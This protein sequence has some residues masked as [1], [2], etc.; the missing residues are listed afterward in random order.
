MAAVSIVIP[1]LNEARTLGACIARAIGALEQCGLDDWEVLVADNGST[2]GSIEI[3]RLAGARVVE[4]PVRGYGAAL[5]QGI[6]AAK[7]PWVLFADADESYDFGELVNFIP[8]LRAG[9]DLVVGN[10]FAGGIAPGAMP[11]LHRY[12]GTPV[13]SFIGRKSFGV[14]LGDFN[15]GMRAI[16]QKA[17]HQLDMRAPG[18]EF[19]SEMIAKAGLHGMQIA[20]VPIHLHRDNRDRKPHLRTWS[21]GWKH[22]RLMLLLS[23]KWLLLFPA[24]FF[25]LAGLLLG[26]LLVIS[27]VEIFNLIL[28]I[29]TLY[30]ASIFL[31]VGVQ[32][33]QFYVLARHY[34]SSMGLYPARGFS[35]AVSRNLGF[36]QSLVAG[37]LLFLLGVALSLLAVYRWQQAGFGP[38]DPVAVFRIIIPAGFCIALGMQVIVFGFLLF[39]LRNSKIN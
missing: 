38:L 6:L 27:Y 11:F 24:V 39:T 3:A 35:A 31:M 29:H 5:H 8:A 16:T 10:R 32:L 21:D 4:V 33:M 26:S 9:A 17:Y 25:L 19:A 1:C 18:M 22:L 30:Y 13:L 7:F 14:K 15:C 37:G 12:L 28:S 34:G 23:P 36:E 2:D 20:E